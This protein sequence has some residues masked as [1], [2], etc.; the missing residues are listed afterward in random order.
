MCCVS[1]VAVITNKENELKIRESNEGRSRRRW[2]FNGDQ[3]RKKLSV[4]SV[5]TKSRHAWRGVTAAKKM[6]SLKVQAI[7]LRHSC[8]FSATSCFDR[9]G[10]FQTADAEHV[11][12]RFRTEKGK[13][14][15]NRS[16]R[17][18]VSFIFFVR[19]RR[20]AA[21][22]IPPIALSAKFAVYELAFERFN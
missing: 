7:R 18:F 17:N 12:D 5:Q 16:D 15:R 21:M 6:S 1:V 11:K 2:G 13:S 3:D 10:S 9:R 22:S 14:P 4:S 19:K 20:R 8:Y